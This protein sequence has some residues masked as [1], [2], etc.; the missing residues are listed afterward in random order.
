VVCLRGSPLPHVLLAR[1]PAGPAQQLCCFPAAR[2]SAAQMPGALPRRAESTSLQRLAVTWRHSLFL[3]PLP[4]LPCL[5]QRSASEAQPSRR[6]ARTPGVPLPRAASV[7]DAQRPHGTSLVVTRGRCTLMGPRQL[8]YARQSQVRLK[9]AAA[10]AATGLAAAAAESPAPSV[11]RE[12][13]SLP[14]PDVA[15]SATAPRQGGLRRGALRQDAAP[16]L[17]PLAARHGERRWGGRLSR[18]RGQALLQLSRRRAMPARALATARTPRQRQPPRPWAALPR[19]RLSAEVQPVTQAQPLMVWC[20]CGRAALGSIRRPSHPPA[21]AF[22]DRSRLS[23]SRSIYLD[24]VR[25]SSCASSMHCR[26]GAV[27]LSGAAD[28]DR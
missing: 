3:L 12:E 11:G 26:S 10:C 2:W 14:L 15:G 18:S 21:A 6:G 9:T 16:R 20:S 7:S 24:L 5:C 28:D 23:R 13:T 22:N 17:P 8:F 1:R 4:P 27:L 25:S 19:W